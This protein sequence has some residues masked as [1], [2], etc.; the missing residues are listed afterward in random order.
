VLR[1]EAV[2]DGDGDDAGGGGQRVD[3]A[4]EQGVEGR[5]DDEVAA[6]VEDE[7]RELRRGR[8]LDAR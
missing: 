4:V 5:A 7:D 6:V 2:A 8:N 3:V 1:R